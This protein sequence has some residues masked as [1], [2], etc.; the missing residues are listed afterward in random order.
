MQLPFLIM[1]GGAAPGGA[2]PF[3]GGRIVRGGP[4]PVK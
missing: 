1:G 4:A 3:V 2:A